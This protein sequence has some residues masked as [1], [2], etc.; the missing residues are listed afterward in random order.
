V[1]VWTR[2][3][4]DLVRSMFV[5]STMIT[6]SSRFQGSAPARWTACWSGVVMKPGY[7]RWRP[8]A[9]CSSSARMRGSTAP[10]WIS[11]TQLS[12]VSRFVLSSRWPC[13]RS[14]VPILVLTSSDEC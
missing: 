7:R 3:H 8:S 13:F 6:S 14:A 1:N 9:R 5:A 2:V 4:G 10:L 12:T 11:P